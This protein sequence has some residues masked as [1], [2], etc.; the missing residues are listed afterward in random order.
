MAP[1]FHQLPASSAL[2]FAVRAALGFDAQRYN[3]GIYFSW[4][5]NV[6]LIS[7]EAMRN[8]GADHVLPWRATD[9]L[10]LIEADISERPIRHD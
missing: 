7:Y 9:Q 3:R 8:M 2:R 4:V 10:R 6:P 5:I 1:V